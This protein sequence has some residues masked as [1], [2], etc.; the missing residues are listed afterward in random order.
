[1]RCSQVFG[2]LNLLQ[3]VL[4]PIGKSHSHCPGHAPPVLFVAGCAANLHMV[5]EWHGAFKRVFISRFHP[6]KCAR[7]E[8]RPAVLPFHKQCNAGMALH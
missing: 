8:C 3:L 1:M 5:V 4:Y 6:I 7:F 2:G